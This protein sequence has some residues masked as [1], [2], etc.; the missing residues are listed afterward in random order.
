MMGAMYKMQ[1]LLKQ[2]D[3]YM[4]KVYLSFIKSKMELGGSIEYIAVAPTH[5]AKL[6]RVQ[7][8]AESYVGALFKLSQTGKKLQFSP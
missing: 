2:S 5:L 7:R 8:A 6:D 1:S 4:R 3:M